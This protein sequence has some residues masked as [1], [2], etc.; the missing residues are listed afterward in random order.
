MPINHKKKRTSKRE[1]G[2]IYRKKKNPHMHTLRKSTQYTDNNLNSQ[3]K[4][5]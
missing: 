1:K 3:Q 2:S 4:H 5:F